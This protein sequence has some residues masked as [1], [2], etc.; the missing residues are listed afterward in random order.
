MPET[1]QQKATEFLKLT[2]SVVR[3]LRHGPREM[4]LAV[5]GFVLLGATT[6]LPKA[7]PRLPESLQQIWS[8]FPLVLSAAGV[9]LLAWSIVRVWRTV[10]APLPD[11]G[12]PKPPAIKGA[13]S[14][15]PHEGE[16]FSRLG[17]DRELAQLRGWILD[18]RVPL[19]AL[20][21]ESG[22]GKTSLLRSGLEYCLRDDLLND[23]KVR[24]FYWE[25]RPSDAAASLLR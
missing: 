17:R 25:A 4:A 14:F 1:S 6:L 12:A 23:E 24:V 3:T 8:A 19:V 13:T 7:D 16:L 5:S 22:V 11:P 2:R 15:G 20:M 10:T 9:V 18:D 21:G